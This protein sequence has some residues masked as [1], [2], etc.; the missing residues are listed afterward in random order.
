MLKNNLASAS[1]IDAV[2]SGMLNFK[3]W[4]ANEEERPAWQ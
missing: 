2:S 1:G 4:L 3:R